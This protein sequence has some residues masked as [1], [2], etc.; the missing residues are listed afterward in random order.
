MFSKIEQF[1]FGLFL[2]L[3]NFAL[4]IQGTPKRSYVAEVGDIKRL[5]C[6]V[7]G[8]PPPSITW[9]KDKQPLKLSERVSKLNNDKTIKI[10]GV[11][12]DDQGNYYCFAENPLGKVNLTF[13]LK[14]RHN[15]NLATTESLSASQKP[16]TEK[17][18][19][20]EQSYQSYRVLLDETASYGCSF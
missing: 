13:E 16:T 12:L 3:E 2:V 14:V 19:K 10:K 7:T 11:R 9:I 6:A 17:Q 4:R 5:R 8:L 20:G 18:I 15:H 1:G